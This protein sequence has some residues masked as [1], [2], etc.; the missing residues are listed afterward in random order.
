[1]R[2]TNNDITTRLRQMARDV[3]PVKTMFTELK[4]SLGADVSIVTLLDHLR[5]AFHLSLAE[6][7]P[8]AALSRNGQRQVEDGAQLEELMKPSIQKHR[9]EWDI[10]SARNGATEEPSD[11]ASLNR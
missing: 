10:C 5:A 8:V 6:V 2:A 9:E 7:K 11:T 3:L 1:M 4:T